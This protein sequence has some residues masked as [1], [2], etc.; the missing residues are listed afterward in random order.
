M[1]CLDMRGRGCIQAEIRLDACAHLPL[2]LSLVLPLAGP[3]PLSA[4]PHPSVTPRPRGRGE[5][6]E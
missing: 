4:V 1:A 3:P 2:V 6:N 5:E